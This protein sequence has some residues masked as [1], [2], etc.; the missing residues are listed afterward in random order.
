VITVVTLLK[1]DNVVFEDQV[2]YGTGNAYFGCEFIRSVLVVKGFPF[3]FENCRFESCAWHIDLVLHDPQQIADLV[4]W[5][6]QIK[7]PIPK[8]EQ[9]GVQSPH[10]EPPAQPPSVS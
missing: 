9:P 8:S 3:H 7:Q 4:S 5:L 1:H 6:E 2:V 10:A